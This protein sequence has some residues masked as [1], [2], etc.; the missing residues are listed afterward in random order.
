MTDKDK[1]NPIKV[2]LSMGPIKILVD[3]KHYRELSIIAHEATV[4][5]VTEEEAVEVQERQMGVAIYLGKG[6]LK[7]EQ[8]T[9]NVPT[10]H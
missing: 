3:A 8:Y 5:V 6:A 9:T 2:C 4:L 7:D 10:R 1:E